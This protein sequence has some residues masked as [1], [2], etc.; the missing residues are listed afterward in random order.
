MKCESMEIEGPEP[1]EEA[2]SVYK[3]RIKNGVSIYQ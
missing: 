2:W 1:G 3:P